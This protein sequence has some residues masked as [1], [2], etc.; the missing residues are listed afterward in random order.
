VPSDVDNC[1]YA[2]NSRLEG[3]P[4]KHQG[5]RDLDGIGDACDTEPDM[6]AWA[7]RRFE[8]ARQDAGP[9]LTPAAT[10][11]CRARLLAP[12]AAWIE[13]DVTCLQRHLENPDADAFELCRANA[14]VRVADSIHEV[15]ERVQARGKECPLGGS[16]TAIFELVD[17][18]GARAMTHYDL[19]LAR[20]D[21]AEEREREV[22]R[23]VIERMA[24]GTPLAVRKG[25][26]LIK[27]RQVKSYERFVT[28]LRDDLAGDFAR[29]E[30]ESALLG[31]R[32]HP[33]WLATNTVEFVR[34]IVNRIAVVN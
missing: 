22:A 23:R 31:V 11:T 27:G 1:P 29:I 2:P 6:P 20:I 7:S 21:M 30:A 25:G 24:D 8:V 12:V 28:R 14:A 33:D 18:L 17:D 5:D 16:P 4:I 3:P 10:R 26:K 9:A 34:A 15:I 13:A 19:V 32:V